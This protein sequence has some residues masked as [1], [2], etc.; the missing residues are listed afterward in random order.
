M[1]TKQKKARTTT[2]AMIITFK[3]GTRTVET[4]QV[5]VEPAVDKGKPPTSIREFRRA[6]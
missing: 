3:N 5:P 4:K 2:S 6:G 1:K